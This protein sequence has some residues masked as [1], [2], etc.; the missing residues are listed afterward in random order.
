MSTQRLCNGIKAPPA[1]GSAEDL[2][3]TQ[4]LRAGGGR[5]KAGRKRKRVQLLDILVATQWRSE[6]LQPA[7]H[8]EDR[9]VRETF[10]EDK[11]AAHIVW[12]GKPGLRRFLSSL[13]RSAGVLLPLCSCTSRGT[14]MGLCGQSLGRRKGCWGHG[15]TPSEDTLAM[16]KRRPRGRSREAAQELSGEEQQERESWDVLIPQRG[17]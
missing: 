14:G 15:V 5:A 4:W 10:L 17:P 12:A 1:L 11:L 7:A 13:H 3:L 6:S 8:G 16:S 9:N 2:V